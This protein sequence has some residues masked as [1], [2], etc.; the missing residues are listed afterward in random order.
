MLF[1]FLAVF[2][3]F[4]SQIFFMID[5]NR[6]VSNERKEVQKTL[7]REVQRFCSS[8]S[9]LRVKLLEYFGEKFHRD[10]PKAI[11]TATGHCCIVCLAQYVTTIRHCYRWYR[12]RI[13]ILQLSCSSDSRHYIDWLFI[14]FTCLARLSLNKCVV[15]VFAKSFTIHRLSDEVFASMPSDLRTGNRS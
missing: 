1:P 2:R 11:Q 8:Y 10:D 7:L 13:W 15:R 12:S 5:Q 6:E 4:L 9:C 14:V 3:C